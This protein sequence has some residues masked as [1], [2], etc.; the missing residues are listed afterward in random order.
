MRLGW[1]LRS[2]RDQLGQLKPTRDR[3]KSVSR[4]RVRG[5][6]CLRVAPSSWNAFIY[7]ISQMIFSFIIQSSSSEKLPLTQPSD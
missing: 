3:G 1:M 4:F 6:S 7:F 5:T 2:Q